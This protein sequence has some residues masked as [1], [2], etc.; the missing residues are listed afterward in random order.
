MT[1]A[2]RLLLVASL[3][4]P[5]TG[6]V[7]LKP[8][9][10]SFGLTDAIVRA[11][12]GE[13]RV[14]E[15]TGDDLAD[16][17][18]LARESKGQR[19]LFAVGPKS[20]EVAA[21]ARGAAVVSLG[22]ANPAQVRTPG[23]YISFYPRLDK[24]FEYLRD[25]LKAKAVGFVFTPARNREIALGFVKAGEAAGV[26]VVPVTVNSTGDLYRSVKPALGKV[27]ALLLAIGDPVTTSRESVEYVVEQ[28]QA[29][30][31]PTVGFLEGLTREG[32]T[33]A[34]VAPPAAMAKAATEAAQQPQTVGKKRIE[35]DQMQVVVSRKAAE[36]IGANPE[37]LGAQR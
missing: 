5:A 26:A 21:E 10:E 31:K 33:L 15:L 8:R 20:A 9:S 24:V 13:A 27:D 14:V 30:K 22:V 19:V 25:T 1:L 28:S 34:L 32:V 12:S 17:S 6:S 4:A 35:V 18:R 2:A 16:S 36:A 11:L 29:A 23:T 37:A 3:A 7:V